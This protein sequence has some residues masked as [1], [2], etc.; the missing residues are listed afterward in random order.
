MKTFIYFV[1]LVLNL[2]FSYAS[3]QTSGGLPPPKVKS[4]AQSQ[5]NDTTPPAIKESAKKGSSIEV[6]PGE[7]LDAIIK[8]IGYEKVVDN[9]KLVS[10]FLSNDDKYRLGLVLIRWLEGEN[11][12]YL[13]EELAQTFDIQSNRLLANAY[14]SGRFRFR[15]DRNLAQVF[16]NRLEILYGNSKQPQKESLRRTLCWIYS[17]SGNVLVD[18]SRARHLCPPESEDIAESL[19]LYAGILS[20]RDSPLYDPG[21]AQQ[22]YKS[23]LKLSENLLCKLN[24]AWNGRSSLSIAREYTMEELFNLAASGSAEY[25]QALNNLGVLHHTGFG[26]VKDNSKAFELFQRGVRRNQFNSIYNVVW[27]SYFR[28][29]NVDTNVRNINDA[30]WL[31]YKY[32]YFSDIDSAIDI[33]LFEQWNKEHGRLPEKTSEFLSFLERK[34][35]AGE[36]RANCMLAAHYALEGQFRVAMNYAESGLASSDSSVRRECQNQKSVIAVRL[37]YG[38]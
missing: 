5:K 33:T 12:S 26:T 27:M 38:R 37:Y 24:L 32:R 16:L 17:D 23:C 29:S 35:K 1:L 3:A 31:I 4:Q 19:S 18:W 10:T 9:H 14:G 25:S 15:K 6:M 13:F 30:N 34:A 7:D 28:D 36:L 21:Q 20:D 22:L 8:R 11:S 2:I